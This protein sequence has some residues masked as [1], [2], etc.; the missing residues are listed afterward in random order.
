MTVSEKFSAPAREPS[1]EVQLDGSLDTVGRAR[2][3]SDNQLSTDATETNDDVAA[4]KD[5]SEGG[6]GNPLDR[7]PSQA[8][9]LG[10]K[11]IAVVM[12]ALC[13]CSSFLL[14][15]SSFADYMANW[16]LTV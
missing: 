7:V 1:P 6:D 5:T 10:G 8:Q 3:S 2:S 15:L 14:V 11:K 9:K 12:G 4:A 16:C 13:V